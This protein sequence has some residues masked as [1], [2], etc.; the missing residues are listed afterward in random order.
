MDET[1]LY[2]KMVR[3]KYDYFKCLE[4]K[5]TP[6]L[7]EFVKDKFRNPLLFGFP[8]NCEIKESTPKETI[9]NKELNKKLQ[10]FFHPDKNPDRIDEATRVFAWLQSRI[11]DGDDFT[12]LAVSQASDMWVE[13]NLQM[14][15]DFKNMEKYCAEFQTS[16]LCNFALKSEYYKSA[17]EIAAIYISKILNT[18]HPY[19]SPK[20]PDIKTPRHVHWYRYYE[21]YHQ[22]HSCL[23]TALACTQTV[24]EW[25]SLYKRAI[26][27]RLQ[28][29]HFQNARKRCDEPHALQLY[30][31]FKPVQ[32]YVELYY[33][34]IREIVVDFRY[35]YVPRDY[36]FYDWLQLE[37]VEINRILEMRELS[38]LDLERLYRRALRCVTNVRQYNNATDYRAIVDDIPGASFWD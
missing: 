15:L 2:K 10:L 30:A 35:I 12:L 38:V 23:Q 19:Y 25:E 24:P 17:D 8:G 13:A 36:E 18:F 1:D 34:E 16:L 37:V 11:E 33:L 5:R 31:F 22:E 26:D 29:E 4:V 9:N 20:L 14:E 32:E 28:F 21:A 3:A 7:A 27:N 6:E